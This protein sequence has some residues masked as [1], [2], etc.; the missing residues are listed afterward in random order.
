MKLSKGMYLGVMAG[1]YIVGIILVF[2]GVGAAFL[3]AAT[4]GNNSDANSAAAGAAAFGGFGLSMLGFLC[5]LASGVAYLML[6]FKA[7]TAINDGQQRTSPLAA[8]LLLLIPLFN[9]YWMFQAVWGWAQ[10]YNKYIARHNVA[11][12]PQ[13]NEQMFL[14]QPIALIA[15]IVPLVGA[16]AALAHLVLLFLNASKMIDGV[17]AIV[18]GAPVAMAAAASK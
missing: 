16:L 9:L 4:A 1:G 18:G 3:G 7:W 6:I 8:A 2:M 13:M 15:C 17:N 12:A 14:F 10:D 5:M 11:G